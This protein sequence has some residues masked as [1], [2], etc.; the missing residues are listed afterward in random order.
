MAPTFSWATFLFILCS[1]NLSEL[2]CRSFLFLQR[3]EGHQHLVRRFHPISRVSLPPSLHH[4]MATRGRKTKANPQTPKPCRKGQPAKRGGHSRITPDEDD[5]DAIALLNV[6]PLHVVWN[7]TR[8][9]RLLDWLENNV[10]DHQRLFSDSS[11]DAR[12]ENRHL[13]MAKNVKTMFYVKIAD[14]VFSIDEDVKVRDN[15]RMHGAK[16]Y[17]KTVENC[18]AT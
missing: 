5:E 14:Y 16:K 2:F 12:D 1:L 18:I 15:L 8:T 9:N 17:S 10:E 13:C 4:S 11:Q 3:G 7:A 6:A